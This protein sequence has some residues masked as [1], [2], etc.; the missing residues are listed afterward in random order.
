MVKLCTHYNF[1]VKIINTEG[2]EEWTHPDF[3]DH[4]KTIVVSIEEQHYYIFL[5]FTMS[6]EE[7]RENLKEEKKKQ[8]E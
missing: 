6:K 1:P 4:T 7:K 5:G 2:H 3:S 8:K